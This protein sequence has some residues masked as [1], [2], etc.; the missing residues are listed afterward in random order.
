MKLPF[1]WQLP[2]REDIFAS[3]WLKPLAPLFDHPCFWTLSRRRAACSVAAG[4][5][6]GLMPGP[7]Q[8]AT[9]LI[10]AW[11]LR[12][13]L[14]LA[15]F[16]TLYSNPFTYLPLY[17]VGYQIGSLLLTGAPATDMPPLPEWGSA[18]YWRQLGQWLGL[19]GKPLLVGVPVL[20]LTLAAIGYFAV[21]KLW[22][23]RTLHRRRQQLR[24]RTGR[25]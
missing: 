6:G 21:S 24:R 20:G 15:M 13:N 23:L 16:T 2:E 25:P 8:M 3:R 18:D 10:I 19:H 14:P 22:Q 5:F 17:Y 7:T 4:L 12:S 1:G 11:L 9:A